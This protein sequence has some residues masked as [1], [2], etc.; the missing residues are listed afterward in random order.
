MAIA[1]LR[2]RRA[3]RLI[4]VEGY[5]NSGDALISNGGGRQVK[6]L[7]REIDKLC[8][9]AEDGLKMLL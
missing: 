4:H 6:R 1:R 8:N 9:E 7:L 3:G 5:R 2:R